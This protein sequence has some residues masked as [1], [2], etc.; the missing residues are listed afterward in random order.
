MN[1]LTIHYFLTLV[2]ERNFTRAAERLHV[3]Q[4]TLSGHIAMVEREVGMKLFIRHVPLELTD[5]GEVF[6]ATRVYSSAMN[7]HFAARFRMCREVRAEC[8]ASVSRP[9]AARFC[10]RPC[11][12]FFTVGIRACASFFARWRMQ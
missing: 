11:S 3:T 1:F 10:C 5:G 12:K 2:G 9:P 8:F 4:Q 7:W 6:I